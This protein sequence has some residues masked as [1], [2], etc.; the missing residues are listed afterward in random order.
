MIFAEVQIKE[1]EIWSPKDV[2]DAFMP[3]DFKK[4]FPTTRCILDA[5]E[6][7]IE[8][9]KH[10]L[11]Q[12][13]TWSTYKNKNT[14]KTMIGITPRGLISYVSDTFGGATSDRQIIERSSLTQDQ[15]LFCKNDSIMAD[16]GIRV[17]DIF[18]S[19]D[20]QYSVYMWWGFCRIG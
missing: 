18:A 10:V 14:L 12:Q 8:K 2:I 13:A 20:V 7:P 4:K 15:N 3:S 5:T 9:P 19:R 6:I 11:D 16:R 1:L 17:Q